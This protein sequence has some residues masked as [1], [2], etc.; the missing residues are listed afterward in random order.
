MGRLGAI[1]HALAPVQCARAV[2]VDH[3]GTF[4]QTYDALIGL[5]GIGPSYRSRHFRDCLIVDS[6]DGNVER[7]V[8]PLR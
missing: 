2:V 7:Y 1:M 4:P 3:G 6:P 8:A 5:P